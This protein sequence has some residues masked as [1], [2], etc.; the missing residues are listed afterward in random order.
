MD[1]KPAQRVF[2]AGIVNPASKD[3]QDPLHPLTNP[4]ERCYTTKKG[5]ASLGA[6]VKESLHHRIPHNSDHSPLLEWQTHLQLLFILQG[7]IGSTTT[8]AGFE[9]VECTTIG[10]Q[11]TRCN[12]A[13]NFSL[14]RLNSNTF[15]KK[16]GKLVTLKDNI[17]RVRGFRVQIGLQD[18]INNV[19]P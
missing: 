2:P 16:P 12:P 17:T 6:E 5:E 15:A 14:H 19:A 9:V 4:Y 13:Q 3:I 1:H 10:I 8:E 11:E 7:D 18:G